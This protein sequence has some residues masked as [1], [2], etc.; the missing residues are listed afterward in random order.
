MDL[1]DYE[2]GTSSEQPPF[3]LIGDKV[4]LEPKPLQEIQMSV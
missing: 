2:S 1:F 3:S 4:T